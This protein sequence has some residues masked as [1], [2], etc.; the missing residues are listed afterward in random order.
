MITKEELLQKG[1]SP[2][3]ADEIISSMADGGSDGDVD[4][5]LDALAKALNDDGQ[6]SLFKADK[7]DDD[8]DEDEDDKK[9][10]DE[11]YDEEYMK[12]HMKKYMKENPSTSKKMM[13]EVGLMGDEMKKA[14]DDFDT[15][16]EGAVVEMTDLAPFLEAQKEFVDSMTKAVKFLAGQVAVI[17]QQQEK[18]FD[19]MKKAG[20][21]SVETAKG[22]ELFLGKS[23][24]R[25]G[26]VTAP[27]KK[28]GELMLT[29][30]NKKLIYK[31]LMKA[32]QAGDDTAGKIISVY[33]SAGQNINALNGAQRKYI[34]ELLTKE[35]Q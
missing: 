29:A 3:V 23:V 34:N 25:K 22:I 27:M 8:D 4:S 33:E 20:A 30:D 15:D 16:A 2:E 11:E 9:D 1:I 6:E 13:K 26:V 28:A 31:T 24:G 5:P 21:V 14:I 7:G 35:A 32:T 17:G 12:K 10:D 19:L 18:S